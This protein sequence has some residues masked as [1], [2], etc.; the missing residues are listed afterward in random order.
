MPDTPKPTIE[1][2]LEAITQ[3]LELVAGMQQ[4]N[5]KA[6][7]RLTGD[8]GKLTSDVDKL[9]IIVTIQNE[10]IKRLEDKS[11]A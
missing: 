8:V 1:E 4:T 9:L 2:R 7:E 3:T 11:A 10:R 5:E 6:I